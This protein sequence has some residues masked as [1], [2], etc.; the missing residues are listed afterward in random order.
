M[1][2]YLPLLKIKIFQTEN[3]KQNYLPYDSRGYVSHLGYTG[4]GTYIRL[5]TKVHQV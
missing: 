4:M 3:G 5:D 1:K 2:A